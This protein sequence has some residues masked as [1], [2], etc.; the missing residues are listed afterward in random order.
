MM[1]IWGHWHIDHHLTI[2]SDDD[3]IIIKWWSCQSPQESLTGIQR[4]LFVIFIIWQWSEDG[5]IYICTH[6]RKR[7]LGF[8]TMLWRVSHGNVFVKFADI[9]ETIEDP[10]TGDMLDKAVFIVFYQVKMLS[11]SQ[12]YRC[13]WYWHVCKSSSV[14]WWSYLLSSPIQWRFDQADEWSQ[15][16]PR[17][18]LLSMASPYCP[19]FDWSHWSHY[20]WLS[21]NWSIFFFNLKANTAVAGRGAEDEGE[22]DLRGFPCRCL[23][24]SWGYLFFRASPNNER[25]N[26]LENWG[27]KGD[28]GRREHKAGGSCHGDD[29]S[30]MVITGV[31]M[32]AMIKMI[33]KMTVR[34]WWWWWWWR[35]GDVPNEGS[36][37]Q[38]SSH[39][40]RRSEVQLFFLLPKSKA[41]SRLNYI[42]VRKMKS[43]YHILNQVKP[44]QWLKS[45]N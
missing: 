20:S 31:V 3:N 4:I 9:D 27:A 30:I 16:A 33:L 8:E 37:R 10:K 12:F 14:G 36:T 13:C 23:P 15:G 44:Q 35:S 24:L 34:W 1:I 28:D 41:S 42:R 39:S 7:T 43:V 40:G 26:F 19:L 25:L 32:I 5:G 17:W 2:W 6:N 29:I 45:K 21:N 11:N 38:T 18:S 22:E